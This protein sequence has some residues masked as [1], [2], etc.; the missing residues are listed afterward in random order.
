MIRKFYD[1]QATYN[2]GGEPPITVEIESLEEYL[3]RYPVPENYTG[4]EDEWNRDRIHEWADKISSL[5]RKTPPITGEDVAALLHGIH[6]HADLIH[7]RVTMLQYNAIS[8][9]VNWEEKADEA[10]EEIYYSEKDLLP[11]LEAL[12]LPAPIWGKSISLKEWKK[13]RK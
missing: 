10:A 5:V 11:V 1:A 2:L 6:T 13:Q 8:D 12:G 4:H 3:Q 9:P 7:S